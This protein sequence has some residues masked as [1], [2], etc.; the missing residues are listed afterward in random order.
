MSPV[1]SAS[2]G[3]SILPNPPCLRGV[4]TLEI[5]EKWMLISRLSIFFCSKSQ[6]DTWFSTYHAKCEK[7]ESVEAATISQSIFRNSSARSENAMI[8]VGQTKV[9][10]NI[11][12]KHCKNLH[13]MYVYVYKQLHKIFHLQI[14]WIKKEHQVLSLV[15]IQAD[16]LKL[17]IHYSSTAETWGRLLDL[18]FSQRHFAYEVKLL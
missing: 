16:F 7:W 14:K 3:M 18:Q 11:N 4:L 5:S 10:S 6:S 9:L 1:L 8:S 12:K 2:N 13:R 15:I 17:A